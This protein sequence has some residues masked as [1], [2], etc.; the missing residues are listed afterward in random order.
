MNQRTF[1]ELASLFF[2]TRQIIRQKMPAGRTHDHN[3]WLRLE[4]LGFIARSKK[5]TMQDI[6]GYVRI[7]APSTTSLVRH[8]E[9]LGFVRRAHSHNDKR[10]VRIQVTEKGKRE[11][12]RYA[13]RSVATMSIVF[14]KLSSQDVEKLRT[15]LQRLHGAHSSRATA[16]KS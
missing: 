9:K 12:Q 14:G 13:R 7:T 1:E 15:I 4:T 8:L 3:A 16:A 5:P 2:S 10:V 11:L 6:A